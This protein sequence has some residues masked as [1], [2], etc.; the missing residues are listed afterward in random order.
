MGLR[1]DIFADYEA[2]TLSKRPPSW[3]AVGAMLLRSLSLRAA[4]YYRLGHWFRRRDFRAAA[5]IFDRLILRCGASINTAA[6]IGP[7]LRI[8]HPHGVVIGQGVRIG[9]RAYILQGVTLGG[10]GGKR[11]PDGQSGPRLGDDVLIG[12]GAKLLGPIRVGSRVRIGA[13]AVVNTDLPDDSTAVGVPARVVKLADKRIPLLEQPGEL[14]GL[15]KEL[16]AKLAELEA[17]IN[18][19]IDRP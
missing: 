18:E 6:E 8:P 13:N 12:A 5:G 10:E 1:Q 3:P 2:V 14:P 15:L 16:F 17:R 7:G 19:M 11:R 9:R 4:L